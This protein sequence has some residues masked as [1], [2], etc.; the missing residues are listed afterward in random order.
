LLRDQM[1][2]AET[3]VA[4]LLGELRQPASHGSLFE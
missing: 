1:A 2:A 4:R 3:A